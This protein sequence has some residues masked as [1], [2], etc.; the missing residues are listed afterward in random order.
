[1]VFLA[2]SGFLL[3]LFVLLNRESRQ[4]ILRIRQ[5]SP[6]ERKPPTRGL[7]GALALSNLPKV[8]AP[9]L[10][11]D[12]GKRRGLQE[13][14]LQAGIYNPQALR[15][16]LGVKMLVISL[17]V[18]L[19]IVVF[20]GHGISGSTALKAMIVGGALGMVLPS[21]WLISRKGRRQTNLRRALP[22][23]LD[24]LVLCLEGGVSLQAAIQRITTEL[25]SAHPLLGAEMN[26]VQR[27]M[28]MGLSAGQALKRLGQRTDLEELRSLAAVL[29]QN[30]RYGVS[31]VKALR[32]YSDT[33]RQQR[34][35]RAEELA[36]KAA[37]KILFPTLLCIFPA[38][39]IVILGPAAFQIMEVFARMRR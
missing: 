38:I 22:D 35:Q 16:F 5:M 20:L 28:L 1:M 8:G 23:A 6:A 29:M 17:G 3:L 10:P 18:G 7:L 15:V 9:L 14:L 4:A 33:L 21:F 19:P 26:I 12:E 37:V 31:V 36:Q 39:F 30:E 11:S 2:T 13:A 34:H 27:E 24:M 32:I 25:V